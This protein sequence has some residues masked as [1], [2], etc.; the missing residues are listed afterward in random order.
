MPAKPGFL[1]K[2]PFQPTVQIIAQSWKSWN[3]RSNRYFVDA[4]LVWSGR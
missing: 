2:K 4:L 1:P 3:G